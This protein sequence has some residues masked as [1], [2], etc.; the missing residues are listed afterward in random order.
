M[1]QSAFIPSLELPMVFNSF[2]LKVQVSFETEWGPY[3]S[4][5]RKSEQV[6]QFQYILIHIKLPCPTARNGNITKIEQKFCGN[7]ARQTPNPTQHLGSKR[8]P[9]LGSCMLRLEVCQCIHSFKLHLF[10]GVCVQTCQHT[11]VCRWRPEDN[12]LEWFSFC[13]FV[14]PR[15]QNSSYHSY[16]VPGALTC[17]AISPGLPAP[18]SEFIPNH[19]HRT[20]AK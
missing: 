6:T 11:M 19:V 12:L 8:F 20:Q 17:R 14:G 15:E 13:H 1:L 3:V 4:A 18:N 5:F 16:Q 2:S 10:I 7:Q 9:C